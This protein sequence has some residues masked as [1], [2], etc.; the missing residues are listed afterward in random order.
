ML[1]LI[2]LP[3]LKVDKTKDFWLV[4]FWTLTI[5]CIVVYGCMV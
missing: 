3:N 5:D 2:T 1:S 4:A